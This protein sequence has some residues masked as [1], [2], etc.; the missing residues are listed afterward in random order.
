V[1]EYPE[2]DQADWFSLDEARLKMN[3][4]QTVFLD[5]LEQHLETREG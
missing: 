3:P 4:A 2:V 1:H 5:R